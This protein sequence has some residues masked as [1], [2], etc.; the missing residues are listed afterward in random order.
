[1]RTVAGIFSQLQ[2]ARHRADYDINFTTLRS[3]ALA[4]IGEAEAAFAAWKTI[5]N[6]QE[7]TVFLAALAFASRWSK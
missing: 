6:T 5:K 4:R 1:L 3:I 7:A 2:Q